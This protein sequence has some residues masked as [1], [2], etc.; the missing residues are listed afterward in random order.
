MDFRSGFDEF[1]VSRI[2]RIVPLHWVCLTAFVFLV[3]FFLKYWWGPGPFTGETFVASAALA[4]NWTSR[5]ALAWNH[6]TWS[7]SAEWL[8]DLVFS[9]LIFAVIR[10]RGRQQALVGLLLALVLRLSCACLARCLWLEHW[11]NDPQPRRTGRD[12]AM[13]LRIYRRRD[14]VEGTFSRGLE[15]QNPGEGGRRVRYSRVGVGL[16]HP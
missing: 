13:P 14:R 5:T 4:Q 1:R 11:I 6:P 9:F 10:L 16:G 8:A 12:S 15:F 7:L 3:T 2:S